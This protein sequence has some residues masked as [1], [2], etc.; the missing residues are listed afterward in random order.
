MIDNDVIRI[1]SGNL[2]P[3]EIGAWPGGQRSVLGDVIT[4]RPTPPR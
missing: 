1:S 2:S 3:R 4:R